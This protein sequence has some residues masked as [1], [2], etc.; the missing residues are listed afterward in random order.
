MKRDYATR[1][2][3]STA[4]KKP[5]GKTAP[6]KR[7]ARK[8]PKGSDNR[9]LAVG[10]VTFNAP[11]FSAGLILGG[12]AVL[13]LPQ[14]VPLFEQ[15][16]GST[17]NTEPSAE[18]EVIFDFDAMLSDSEVEIDQTAYEVEF[19]DPNG[20]GEKTYLLQ[21]A[22]FRSFAQ[23][24][25]LQ[26]LL[27]AQNLPASVS[28]MTVKDQ[29]WYRVTVGPFHRKQDFNRAITALRENNLAPMQLNG[30]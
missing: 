12:A 27:S 22:S 4:R 8:D 29:R 17:R 6:R 15:A 26:A 9:P 21:A 7:R 19:E 14:V 2:T 20:D 24:A 16:P 5:A 11:S 13:L 10:G 25:N 23:A 18:L 30:G 1:A 3:G 28:H